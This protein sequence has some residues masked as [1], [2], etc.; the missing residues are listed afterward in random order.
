MS[1]LSLKFSADLDDL[2]RICRLTAGMPLGIE[3]AAGWVDVLSLEQIGSELQR[4]LDILETD[5]RDVPERQRSLRVTFE[6]TW[7]RLSDEEQRVFM[8]LSVFRVA[9]RSKRRGR[10]LRRIYVRLRKLAN[11]ALVQVSPDRS[12]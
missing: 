8:R 7:E 4:G 3:L 11:K 12:A 1:G 6:H 5:L 2:A 9:S 10:L